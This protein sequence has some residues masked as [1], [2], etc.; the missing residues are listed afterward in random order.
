MKTTK[1]T[2]RLLK[3]LDETEPQTYTIAE[4]ATKFKKPSRLIYN[5][6]RF[7]KRLDRVQYVRNRIPNTRTVNLALSQ[8][9]YSWL[10]K[11]K[12]HGV[13]VSGWINAVLVDAMND[14]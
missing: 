6:I 11:S 1:E 12:P 8:D 3:L 5:T 2:I 7:H 14:N 13:T 9:V 4:L 10:E